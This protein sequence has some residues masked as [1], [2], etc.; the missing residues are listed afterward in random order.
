MLAIYPLQMS[1]YASRVGLAF[2]D[3]KISSTTRAESCRSGIATADFTDP[4][5]FVD[6]GRCIIRHTVEKELGIVLNQDH[7][8][9]RLLH[10]ALVDSMTEEVH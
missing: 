4:V 7:V 5:N 1:T 10:E 6:L 9:V 8:K 3:R 2:I